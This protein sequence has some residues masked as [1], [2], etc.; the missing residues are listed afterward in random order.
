M[1]GD[2]TSA[3][4]DAAMTLIGDGYIRNNYVI[5]TGALAD[6]ERYE[7][8]VDAAVAVWRPT[9]AEM[10]KAA[11]DHVLFI[12]D[13]V[14]ADYIEY[15]ARVDEGLAASDY[16][17]VYVERIRSQR[18]WH[19][20]VEHRHAAELRSH[21]LWLLGNDKGPEPQAEEIEA[22]VQCA[23][24]SDDERQAWIVLLKRWDQRYADRLLDRMV[25]DSLDVETRR[26]ALD[27]VL[28]HLP[29]RMR[30]IVACLTMTQADNRLVQLA[31][32][33]AQRA[34]AR[35]DDERARRDVALSLI[36]ALPDVYQAIAR[37]E[38]AIREGG[39]PILTPDV[40][41]FVAS[42]DDPSEDVRSMRLRL[43]QY[44]DIDAAEDAR[45]VLAWSDGDQDALA[46]IRFAARHGMMS[47]VEKALD[48]KFAYVAAAALT[49]L[50]DPMPAP[51]P[52][53]ILERG[54]REL[55]PVRTALLAQLRAKPHEA[56]IATLLVLT[57]DQWSER[58][59]YEKDDGNYPVAR[60]AA[61]LIASLDAISDDV[62]GKLIDHAC[63]TDDLG[64]M[65][66][67]LA[68]VV[69]HGSAERRTEVVE[70]SRYGERMAVRRA[71]A[72]AL[73]ERQE[74]LADETIAMLDE[75]MVLRLP[76]PIAGCYAMMIGLR[77]RADRVDSLAAGLAA[78]DD[79]RIFLALLAVALRDR[80]PER[81]AKI[82]AML[83]DG[84][85]ARCWA[86]S[87]EVMI[88]PD[89]LIDL[90]DASS[91]NEALNWMVLTNA[92]QD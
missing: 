2:V 32:D 43:A 57:H 42:I 70:L 74:H 55:K 34:A 88:S 40:R 48:H 29:N 67:M 51:L 68:C 89:M 23:I 31:G 62:L 69:K 3:F 25:E 83:P 75:D 18:G 76:A 20:L 77:G 24:G 5:A 14:D 30:D 92:A 8:V 19:L 38:L 53:A 78:S 21:W 1:A 6:P 10:D 9:R 28:D 84:H 87:D 35:K 41:A 58:A 81:S 79:R 63:A 64:L 50:A 4:F 54:H 37:A 26:A 52:R 15:A 36:S 86:S 45:E 59:P 85:P 65:D 16:L 60:E 73:F 61:D 91:V 22:A 11:N 80:D 82:A 44:G 72:R 46:A 49:A 12:N 56:H 33:L 27:C 66:R 7:A 71:A 39:A 17:A 47:E 90:G 13:E